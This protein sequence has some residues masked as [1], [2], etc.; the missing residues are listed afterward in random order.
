MMKKS[1]FKSLLFLFIAGILM[2]SNSLIVYSFVADYNSNIHVSTN[3][4]RPVIFSGS[5]R[6]DSSVRTVST[7]N[8]GIRAR[9]DIVSR[10]SSGG[11]V[12]SRGSAGWVTL[13]AGTGT[14]SHGTVEGTGTLVGTTRF[15][16]VTAQGERRATSTASWGQNITVSRTW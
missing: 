7:N 13:T 2:V 12:H 11:T 5:I 1:S 15:G 8:N 16:T 4:S 10:E 6:G 14:L 3:A 9:V